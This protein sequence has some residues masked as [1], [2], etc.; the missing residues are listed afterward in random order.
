MR[1]RP[2]PMGHEAPHPERAVGRAVGV[3]P[4][5][6]KTASLGIPRQHDL[7]VRLNDDGRRPA[8]GIGQCGLATHAEGTVGRAVRIEPPRY[9]RPRGRAD[10][11]TGHN[12]FSVALDGDRRGTVVVREVH[13]QVHSAG[14]PE[15]G[16]EGARRQQPA[17]LKSF[18]AVHSPPFL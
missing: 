4:K 15:R 12:E 9:E 1:S 14:I 6:R 8:F 17:G 11:L 16:I 5:E 2:A 3:Q 7:A 18:Q 10:R 13:P